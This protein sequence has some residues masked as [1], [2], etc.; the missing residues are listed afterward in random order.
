MAKKTRRQ[1]QRAARRP[2]A[3]S[4]GAL[5]PGIPRQPALDVAGA[6]ATDEDLAPG[7]AELTSAVSSA[8]A[9]AA[10]GG[11][12]RRRIE[13]VTPTAAAAR[14]AARPGR[15]PANAAA[16]FAPLE[17]ED[18][19]IPFDRVPYVPSDLRRVAAMAGL[20]VVLIIIAAVIVSRV[21]T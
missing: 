10:G 12:T 1:K 14:G 8:P 7:D 21:V 11:S 3:S 4:P 15:G 20:M 13:R 9:A 18:A 2:I 6:T 16:M 19:A 17:S 5:T